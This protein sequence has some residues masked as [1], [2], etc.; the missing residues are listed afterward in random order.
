MT[1]QR[2]TGRKASPETRD[3][4][5]RCLQLRLSGATY[6]QIAAATG[7]AT[8]ASAYNACQSALDE[9]ISEAA[10]EVITLETARLDRLLFAVWPQAADGHLGAV[11]RAIRI[12]ERRARLLGLDRTEE[13][14]DSQLLQLVEALQALRE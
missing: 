7:Y 11:D 1:R 6:R 8:A 12:M 10:E 14:D 9:Q 5:H 4:W 3:K 2:R 13:G